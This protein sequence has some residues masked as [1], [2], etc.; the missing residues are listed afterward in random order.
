MKKL[1]MRKCLINMTGMPGHE[2]SRLWLSKQ[3]QDSG[4]IPTQDRKN[5][6]SPYLYIKRYS[7]STAA[8]RGCLVFSMDDLH[9]MLSKWKYFYSHV[10]THT[11]SASSS[12]A[13]LYICR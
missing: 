1:A 11:M 9:H 3:E 2:I 6:K 5:L 12:V 10:Y 13:S 4:N 8:K 7:Q